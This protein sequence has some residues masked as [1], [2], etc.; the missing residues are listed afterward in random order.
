[1]EPVTTNITSKSCPDPI[2][3]NCVI[4][5]TQL[6]GL[7]LCAGASITDV[8]NSLVT[9]VNSSN[10]TGPCAAAGWKDFSAGIPTSGA[11]A[12]CTWS[13]FGLQNFFTDSGAFLGVTCDNPMYKFTNEGDLKL[14]G[15]FDINFNTIYPG[16]GSGS[17]GDVLI[18]LCTVST[19]C[20]PTTFTKA[21]VRLID[22]IAIPNP[23]QQ[24][25]YLYLRFYAII[26][27][28]GLLQVLINYDGPPS[29]ISYNY[30]ITLGAITFNLT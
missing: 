29:N 14:R 8:L 24:N 22:S 25:S 2:G 9:L 23:G 6:P 1:M 20:L 27:P 28:G 12:N 17:V 18:N 10:T 4:L 3:S 11:G 21:Q 19:S 16:V 15:C 26:N 5:S 30:P 7:N 13:L